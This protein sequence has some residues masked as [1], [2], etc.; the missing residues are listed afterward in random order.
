V[1]KNTDTDTV[2]MWESSRIAGS[3][4]LEKFPAA[5]CLKVKMEVEE[6]APVKLA[7]SKRNVTANTE[8]VGRLKLKWGQGETR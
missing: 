7:S 4:S 8:P 6:R 2:W 1:V 3:A 5:V